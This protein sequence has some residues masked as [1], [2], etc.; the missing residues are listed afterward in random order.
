MFNIFKRKTEKKKTEETPEFHEF[1]LNGHPLVAGFQ[2]YRIC[3]GEL[4]EANDRKVYNPQLSMPGY[5]DGLNKSGSVGYVD[6]VI[7]NASYEGQ[8]VQA[9]I[10]GAGG[11]EP[12]HRGKGHNKL[13]HERI[14]EL[15]REWD[16][17]Y[18]VQ[19][20]VLN[21]EVQKWNKQHGY[22]TYDKGLNWI[23]KISSE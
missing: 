1:Y 7:M 2:I 6:V 12:E 8:E 9:L 5:P 19:Q 17:E 21:S 14:E 22:I 3:L 11:I 18:I 23:K 13:L 15:A 20:L 10:L 4:I 16:I